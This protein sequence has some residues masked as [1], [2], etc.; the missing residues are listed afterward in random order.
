MK[1]AIRKLFEVI[2]EVKDENEFFYELDGGDE[3]ADYFI[4]LI[5]NYSPTEKEIIKSDCHEQ[6]LSNL[7]LEEQE[8][9]VDGFLVFE[10]MAHETD[11][12]ILRVNSIDEVEKIIFEKPGITNMFTADI[13]VLENGKRK[14]YYIR[15]KQGN[16]L[17]F[18]DFYRKDYK[19][20]DD[21]YFIQWI[22]G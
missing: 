16:I 13:V 11:Y 17:N 1:Y 18:E 21:E 5:T 2:D 14:K 4:G 19:D 10:R 12:R 20:L 7:S 22:S 9:D 3:G 15:D 6:C 8:V